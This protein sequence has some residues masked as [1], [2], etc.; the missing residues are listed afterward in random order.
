MNGNTIREVSCYC[1]KR[2]GHEDTYWSYYPTS[3]EKY[4]SSE[5]TV[6]YWEIDIE[7]L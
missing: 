4:E 3:L 7:G 5:V 1:W 2:E 6:M